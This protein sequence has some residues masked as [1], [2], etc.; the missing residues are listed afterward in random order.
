MDQHWRQLQLQQQEITMHL[1]NLTPRGSLV[2][3]STQPNSTRPGQKWPCKNIPI[4]DVKV[5][6][7]I[8]AAK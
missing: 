2:L 1:Q 7:Y 6:I 8:G 5:D 3:L 4:K